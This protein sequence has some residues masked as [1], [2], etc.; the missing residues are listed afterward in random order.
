MSLLLDALKK[1]AEQKAEKSREDIPGAETSDETIVVSAP[2]D[3]SELEDPDKNL[4]DSRRELEDETQIDDSRLQTQLEDTQLERGADETS[5]EIPDPTETQHTDLSTQMQT[6]EDETIVFDEEDVSDFMGEPE[7]VNRESQD[8]TRDDQTEV[9]THVEPGDEPPAGD[10]TEFDST[11]L[12]TRVRILPSLK[13]VVTKPSSIRPITRQMS[14]QK[15]QSPP[16][17]RPSLTRPSRKK[18]CRY[19]WLSEDDTDFTART[20][21][22]DPQSLQ[23]RT[24]T[25]KRDDAESDGSR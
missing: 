15:I 4:L 16:R 9:Q 11:S 7:L 2:E 20:S 1:A 22:T 18:T 14:R 23:D 12:Q 13:V 6:G 3:I 10:D 5:I 25:I 17:A 19:Y 24:E 21:L 8:E